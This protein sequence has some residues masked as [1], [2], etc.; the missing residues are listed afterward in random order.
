MEGVGQFE[1]GCERFCIR[2]YFLGF[3]ALGTSDSG[4]DWKGP[5][6]HLSSS[7]EKGPKY[8]SLLNSDWIILLKWSFNATVDSLLSGVYK[9]CICGMPA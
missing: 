2:R 6:S 4:E 5:I 1:W 9:R 7:C 3:P 8:L